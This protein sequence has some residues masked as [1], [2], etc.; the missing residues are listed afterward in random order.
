MADLEAEEECVLGTPVPVSAALDIVEFEELVGA[1]GAV[2]D[3]P[4]TLK[5]PLTRVVGVVRDQELVEGEELKEV[6]QDYMEGVDD[7]PSRT[8][9]KAVAIITDT[10]RSF[11][12]P[13]GGFAGAAQTTL[14]R[15][16]KAN[17]FV[18]RSGYVERAYKLLRQLDLYY[19]VW[20]IEDL[21]VYIDKQHRTVAWKRTK[22]CEILLFM[23]VES[24]FR[25]LFVKVD[26][27]LKTGKVTVL[28]T[29]D[30]FGFDWRLY[31]KNRPIYPL[32][33]GEF[34]EM[35]VAAPMKKA[36]GIQNHLVR[37]GQFR[38][39][40]RFVEQP[41]EENINEAFAGCFDDD[42]TL[43]IVGHGDDLSFATRYGVLDGDLV[44]ADQ[45]EGGLQEEI[46]EAIIFFSGDDAAAVQVM[47]DHLSHMEDTVKVKTK[48]AYDQDITL[49]ISGQRQTITGECA[50]ALKHVLSILPGCLLAS[51]MFDAVGDGQHCQGVDCRKVAQCG[52][53]T[54][55]ESLDD[56]SIIQFIYRFIFAV[57]QSLANLGME[58]DVPRVAYHHPQRLPR[59][60]DE[61]VGYYADWTRWPHAMGPFKPDSEEFVPGTFLGGMIIRAEEFLSGGN[62]IDRKGWDHVW[63]S[64]SVIKAQFYP[65]GVFKFKKSDTI[66]HELSRW[67]Y[68]CHKQLAGN[69][70]TEYFLHAATAAFLITG[71]QKDMLHFFEKAYEYWLENV[72]EWYKPVYRGRYVVAWESLEKALISLGNSFIFP[73]E[74]TDLIDEFQNKLSS[75]DFSEII[76]FKSSWRPLFVARFGS[77]PTERSDGANG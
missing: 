70:V 47:A 16:L 56:A 66:A 19:Q 77:C 57:K 64:L 49:Q 15:I 3:N 43:A 50:T 8:D 58:M 20:D 9:G 46:A 42:A 33:P 74:S 14:Q 23:E 21:I 69:P 52:P 61:C 18:A 6:L 71:A 36:A 4:N 2:Y 12:K 40:Y 37:E 41:N 32:R 39:I 29:H 75:S 27:I 38:V 67:F 54:A 13:R 34:F 45:T 60:E 5:V 59:T 48:D 73:Y 62:L 35:I 53:C 68:V 63:V 10:N 55:V 72:A 44:L 28:G 51:S 1:S 25:L 65:K 7:Q 17:K 22:I 24:E 31:S 26:E 11:H 30:L 76:Q